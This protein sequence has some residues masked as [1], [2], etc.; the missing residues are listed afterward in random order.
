[1]AANTLNEVILGYYRKNK[2]RLLQ[3]AIKKDNVQLSNKL[4][5][6]YQGLGF[7]LDDIFNDVDVV[8]AVTEKVTAKEEPQNLSEIFAKKL[9]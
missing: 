5:D 2:K 4:I 3:E 6:L 1:M 8:E 9:R 7:H